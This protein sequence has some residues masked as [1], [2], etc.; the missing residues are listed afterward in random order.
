MVQTDNP[1]AAND[2]IV[3]ILGTPSKKRIF[4]YN[5]GWVAFVYSNLGTILLVEGIRSSGSDM[6]IA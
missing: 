4:H 3:D 6:A 1:I 5:L 2:S